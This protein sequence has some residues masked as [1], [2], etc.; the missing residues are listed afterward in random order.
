MLTRLL[1][2]ILSVVA[3]A[4]ILTPAIALGQGDPQAGGSGNFIPC[5]GTTC[6]ACHFVALANKIIAWLIG[7][8]AIIFAAM[9]VWSGFRLV[10]SGGNEAAK[11]AAK[12]S[13]TNAVVGILIVLGAWVLIDTI[14]KT[15]VKEDSGFGPWNSIPCWDQRSAGIVEYD[16][17]TLINQGIYPG[18]ADDTSTVAH[19]SGSSGCSG[20]SCVA[21]TIPCSA[22][23]C[24][25][26][27]DM[28]SRLAGMHNAAGVSGARVTEAMPPSRE[29]L[30]A[31]HTNGTC[32]DY[33]KAGGMTAAEV[34]KVISA[35]TANGLR[36]VYEVKTQAQKD[37]LVSGGVN[38]SYI[39]VLGNHISAPH[40]SIYGY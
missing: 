8:L 27:S 2:P 24:S 35:A 13:L 6:S 1:A 14:M 31:C 25:I 21:L 29:H 7:I 20:G 23:G 15:L 9:M 22:R 11:T 12:S 32:V 28:V 33:S 18:S 19:G 34:N 4:V 16:A 30:S 40:F 37:Q 38:A 3:L 39:K 36:P 26:A 10:I 17:D 5:S